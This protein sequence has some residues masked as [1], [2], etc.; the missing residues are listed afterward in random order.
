MSVTITVALAFWLASS[1]V[2]YRIIKAIPSSRRLFDHPLGGIIVSLAIGIFLGM[3]LGPSVGV[4]AGLGQILGLATNK[5]T[6]EMYSFLANAGKVTRRHLHNINSFFTSQPQRVREAAN[7]IRL[8]LKG[9]G[10]IIMGFLYIVGLPFRI[11]EWYTTR[12]STATS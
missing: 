7:T 2:E 11:H 4:G 10:A 6:F 9:V 5:L 12:R 1:Y 8:G 3:A